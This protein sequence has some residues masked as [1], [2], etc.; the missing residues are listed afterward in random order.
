MPC[1][2]GAIF[3][4]IL[5]DFI[6]LFNLSFSFIIEHTINLSSIEHPIEDK[7]WPLLAHLIISIFILIFEI[8]E[9]SLLILANISIFFLYFPFIFVTEYLNNEI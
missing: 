7:D 5:P 3:D 9:T 8:D 1:L 4:T 6:V 2:L